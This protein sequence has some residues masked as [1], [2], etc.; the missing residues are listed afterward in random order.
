MHEAKGNARSLFGEDVNSYLKQLIEDLALLNSHPD[1]VIRKHPA[2][3]VM[4][5]VE[6]CTRIL[7]AHRT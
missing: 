3:V 7:H 1:D 4:P 6:M 2:N 5:E